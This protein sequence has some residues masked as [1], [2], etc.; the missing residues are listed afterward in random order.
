[1]KTLKQLLSDKVMKFPIT[2]LFVVGFVIEAQVR[3]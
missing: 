2:Q 3:P 1:M